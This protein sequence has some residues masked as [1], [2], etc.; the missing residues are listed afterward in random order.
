MIEMTE[1]SIVLCIETATEICSIALYRGT[2]LLSEQS[3]AEGY[4][5]AEILHPQIRSCVRDAG[6]KIDAI[7]A[8]AVS[9]G[10]GSYT[11]LR[12]GLSA[13]QGLSFALG[14][15]V[16]GIPTLEALADAC[17]RRNEEARWV[18]PMIDARRME[19]Y[20]AVFDREM[21]PVLKPQAMVLEEES[22]SS[23]RTKEHALYVC[24]NG[25]S[26]W[27]PTNPGCVVWSEELWCSARHLIRPAV[28]QMTDDQWIAPEEL[29]PIYIKSPNITR[30]QQTSI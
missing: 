3:E 4:Q 8:V 21:N 18:A 5:H 25:S 17:L 11:G 30:P 14:I 22:F 13:A 19:V 2:E 24:G 9:L 23:L 28:A 10:P 15:P 12:S 26:K 16:H 1:S 6:M 20:T 27:K 29:K 7:D